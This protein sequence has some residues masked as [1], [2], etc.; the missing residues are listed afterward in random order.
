MTNQKLLMFAMAGALLPA[1]DAAAEVR[2][3]PFVKEIL[4]HPANDLA[5]VTGTAPNVRLKRT[6][7]EQPGHENG[8]VA[9]FADGKSG[10]YFAASTELPGRNVGDPVRPATKRVQ[11][12]KVPFTL[13]Q[14]PN[15]Q[16]Q[17]TSDPRKAE[18]ITNNDGN[19]YR[20]S[21]ASVAFTADEGNAVCVRY[22]YQPNNTNDTK[23]YLQCFNAA[24][25]TLLPQTEAFAK[26]NDD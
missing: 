12:A 1:A 16:V 4:P 19:E 14:A 8:T 9:L 6:D 18:F 21:N 22:N 10:L 20:N 24:G 2:G 7:E 15:G 13:T 25:A 26:T 11:L 17:V 3:A 23:M 5:P